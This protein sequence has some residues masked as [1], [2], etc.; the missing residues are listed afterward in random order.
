MRYGDKTAVDGL[1][2]EIPRGVIAAVLGRN[3][4]GKTTTL[5]VCEG[6]RRPQSGR[7]QVLGLD[8]FA[9]RAELMPRIGVM[10]QEGGAW[11]GARATEML[12]H[13]AAL[14]RDPLPIDHLVERLWL[15]DCG[16][17]PYRR[18]SGGQKQRL[19][20][21]LAI[22]GRPEL[23]FVDEP[24]AGM[25]VAARHRTWD[26]LKDLR[27]DGVSVVL[28]T[29]YLEE[30]EQLADQVHILDKG[31]L[32]ASGTPAELTASGTATLRLVTSAPLPELF[33]DLG[34]LEVQRISD[35][36]LV[37]TGPVTIST[38]AHV[39]AWCADQGIEPVSLGIGRQDLEAVFLEATET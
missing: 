20:L 33:A 23:V 39:T 4:A 18:L 22:I 38:L 26:L 32:I 19:A 24:T 6:F 7:V 21:A 34:D 37:V 3:G 1:N 5:E 10:L 16:R 36:S 12:R 27:A 13:I 8:P 2:L 31:R 17:T 30:A 9:D 11:G 29:H 25:D 28:T 35:R 14:H 15:E